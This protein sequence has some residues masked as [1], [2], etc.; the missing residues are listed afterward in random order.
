MEQFRTLLYPLGLLSA[1]LFTSRFFLQ[2]ISSEKKKESRVTRSFWLLSIA[3]N[4]ILALHALI[5]SQFPLAVLQGV[6]AGIAWR[7]L[8]LMKKEP[9]PFKQFLPRMIALPLLIA[10]LFL[11]QAAV[12]HSFEWMRPPTML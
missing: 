7:N 1:L 8:D 4:A 9:C 3:G 5:Q 6:G 2:W 12:F 10:A 11:I